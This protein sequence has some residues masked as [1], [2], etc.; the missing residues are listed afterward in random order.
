MNEIFTFISHWLLIG[1]FRKQTSAKPVNPQQVYDY[2]PRKPFA[3]RVR[4]SAINAMPPTSWK[5]D[6]MSKAEIV[7]ITS[8]RSLSQALIGEVYRLREVSGI[9]LNSNTLTTG[10]G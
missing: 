6:S 4:W 5:T 9:R 1:L 2:R 8:L 3:F 10:N 7:Q